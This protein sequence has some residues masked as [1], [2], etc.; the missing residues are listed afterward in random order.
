LPDDEKWSYKDKVEAYRKEQD[1]IPLSVESTRD[2]PVGKEN[3]R[4]QKNHDVLCEE[5]GR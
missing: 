2:E 3:S 4:G 5:V 1:E